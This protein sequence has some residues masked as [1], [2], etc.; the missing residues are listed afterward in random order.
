MSAPIICIGVTL[1]C[2]A[3]SVMVY[4]TFRPEIPPRKDDDLPEG[5]C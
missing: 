1:I 4:A 2:A 3:L 5:W